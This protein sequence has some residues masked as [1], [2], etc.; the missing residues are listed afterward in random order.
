MKQTQEAIIFFHDIRGSNAVIDSQINK[1]LVDHPEKKIVAISYTIGGSFEKA[2]VIFDS[3][4][5]R[6]RNNE[7]G[8]QNSQ[9]SNDIFKSDRQGGS[10]NHKPV[11]E[12]SK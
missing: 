1:Y 3:K 11:P 5:E 12:V 7:R 2:I 6:D 10:D 8:R 9:T 4:E